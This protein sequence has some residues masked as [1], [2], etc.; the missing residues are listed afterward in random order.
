MIPGKRPTWR[1]ILFYVFIFNCNSLHVSS[2]SCSSSGETNCVNTTSDSR[3]F[4]SVAVP[5]AGRKCVTLV[6]YQAAT[7]TC[8]HVIFTSCTFMH[9]GQRTGRKACIIVC[10]HSHLRHFRVRIINLC[11]CLRRWWQSWSGPTTSVPTCATSKTSRLH[12]S[13]TRTIL[14]KRW[15]I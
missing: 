2:T 7:T 5:C 9:E 4:V 3:H 13:F 14:W 12:R 6:I 11:G 10:I 15:T 8:H 1:T